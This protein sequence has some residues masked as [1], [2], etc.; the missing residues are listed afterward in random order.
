L[1]EI[2]VDKNFLKHL[3]IFLAFL[4]IIVLFIFWWLGFYTNHNQKIKVENMIGKPLKQFEN[5]FSLSPF[6]LV[7]ADSVFQLGKPGGII[8][9]QNPKPGSEVKKNRLIYLTIT[10]YDPDVIN[11]G[12]L[13]PLYGNDFDQKTKELEQRGI[14][15]KIRSKKY[16]AGEPNHILEVYYKDVLIVND[17]IQNNNVNINK[18]DYLEFVVSSRDEGD[19]LLPDITCM[20]VSE[21]D[22]ILSTSNLVIGEIISKGAITDT[23]ESYIIDQNP[24]SDGSFKIS[25]GSR[26][27]ITI[28]KG[29]PAKC[30]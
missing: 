15:T 18:G 12:E 4:G 13:P 27:N 17:Q 30:E 22:L 16:D 26:V 10:K 3:L 6:K 9:D 29:K 2:K 7:V 23:T 25:V 21:A 5:T 19:I 1:I 14:F 20:T 24:R 11:S 8:V 28:M